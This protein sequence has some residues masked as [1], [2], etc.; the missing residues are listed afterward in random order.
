[1]LW[2]KPIRVIYIEISVVTLVPSQRGLAHLIVDSKN[3]AKN[4][5]TSRFFE[6]S[7]LDCIYWWFI[8]RGDQE[9]DWDHS[10]WY[11]S[12][13]WPDSGCTFV[14]N[15]TSYALYARI[16]RTNKRGA[17]HTL[18]L[19]NNMFQMKAWQN[20]LGVNLES[21]LLEYFASKDVPRQWNNLW[22]CWLDIE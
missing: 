22:Y 11:V 20:P 2:P 8:W 5:V 4:P 19:S 21:T 3:I 12:N 15:P 10:R 9:N 17:S 14:S 6:S 16:V 13:I 7:C 1:M 18:E